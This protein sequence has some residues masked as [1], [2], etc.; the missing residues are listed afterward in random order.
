MI[1]VIC[2]KCS[3]GFFCL[4]VWWIS[5]GSV[6]IGWLWLGRIFVLIMVLMVVDFFV[7]MVLIIVSIIFSWEILC[8]LLFSIVWCL[9]ILGW[10]QGKVSCGVLFLGIERGIFF[11]NCNCWWESCNRCL[12]FWFNLYRVCVYIENFFLK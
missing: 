5:V 9:V 8:N 7:F 2:E 6:V 1:G 11:S 12:V 4:G 3:I 10:F